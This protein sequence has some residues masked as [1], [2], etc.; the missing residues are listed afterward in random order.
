VTLRNFLTFDIEEW[1]HANYSGVAPA[2]AERETA[3]ESQVERLIELCAEHDVRTTCF[4]LGC[5]AQAK[6]SVVR[7]LHAAGH[8]IASH[9][10]AHELVCTMGPA[11]FAEDL[12]VSCALLEDITGERVSGFRAPSFS[13]TRETLAWY[14]DVL[15]EAG[16]AYSSSVFPGRTFLHGVPDFPA[17]IHRP[18]VAGKR[19]GIVEF[20]VPVVRLAGWQIG[21]YIRLFPAWAIARRIARENRAGN[22]VVLY[23]HPREIDPAQPR[24]PL[25]WPQSLIH[26]WGIRGCEAK[27][28]ALAETHRFGRMK[29]AVA[30]F[31]C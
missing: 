10:C 30:G 22:P 25:R 18:V 16:L 3:L 6:P 31:A 29:D 15:E 7:K 2:A 23:V 21:L 26:Y 19:R 20:P 17:R 14:Y 1:H 8:E 5:I 11:R 27:L 12:R 13:V 24:L 9:G 28:R 4:V